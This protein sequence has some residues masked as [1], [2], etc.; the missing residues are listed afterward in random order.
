VALDRGEAV[1]KVTAPGWVI[2][3]VEGK[4]V[5]TKMELVK[6][7][8]KA[9]AGAG[10]TLNFVLRELPEEASMPSTVVAVKQPTRSHLPAEALAR[11]GTAPSVALDRHPKHGYGLDLSDDLMVNSVRP[12]AQVP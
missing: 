3:S 2:V 7:L 10:A 6:A 9:D 8:Q 11:R 4:G 12:P 1:G 5:R